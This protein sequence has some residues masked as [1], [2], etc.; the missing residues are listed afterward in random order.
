MG[1]TSKSRVLL[2]AGK[3]GVGKTSVASA[4]GVRSAQ[5]GK[6]TLIMSLDTAHSLADIFDLGKDLMD[7][8]RGEP[9]QV[10]DRLWIRELDIEEEIRKT[11]GEVHA[12]FA[13]LFNTS[14]FDEVLAEELAIIPG[15]EEVS[16]LLYINSYVRNSEYDTIILDCAPTGEALRFISIPTALEWYIKKIF[17]VERR[18]AK[19]FR[20]VVRHVTDVPLPDDVYFESLERLFHKLQGVGALLT[21]PEVTTVRLVTNPEKIVLKETQRAYMYFCLYR[22]YIDAVIIN[23]ILP[24]AVSDI[25]FRDWKDKQ[26]QYIDIAEQYFNP[27][28]IFEA[29]LFEKEVLGK[30]ALSDLADSIYGDR[31]PN[32]CFFREV[33]YSITKKDTTY[34][35][36]LKLPF[37]SKKDVDVDRVGNELIVR[38]G[39]FKRHILLPK[40]AASSHVVR[41]RLGTDNLIVTLRRDEYGEHE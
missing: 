32:K 41:A 40:G 28:P 6:K 21:D 39:S 12:Y 26:K 15:M 35:I 7:K 3:G 17:N 25:F 27:V 30:E 10:G 37:V 1:S 14:G 23:R 18:L 8:N 29:R 20:P 22:M 11:W 19:V 34:S 38:V 13:S 9:L 5:N 33:P 36:S 16:S 24:D 4:T 2:F 31:D